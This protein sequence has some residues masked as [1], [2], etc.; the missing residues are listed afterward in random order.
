VLLA[1]AAAAGC[2]SSSAPRDVQGVDAGRPVDASALDGSD[3]SRDADACSVAC[4]GTCTAG[5]CLETLASGV[6]TPVAIAVDGT[7]VYATIQSTSV[8]AVSRGG[9]T[10]VTLAARPGST[11]SAWG[12][13]T[14]AANVYWTEQDVGVLSAPLVGGADGGTVAT[15][16]SSAS[17]WGLALQGDALYWSQIGVVFDLTSSEMKLDLAGG[18]PV[19]L[20]SNAGSP[21]DV[22]T[23]AAN[24]YWFD[25]G[26][27]AILRTPLAGGAVTTLA[28]QQH[29]TVL[30][31][32]GAN[33]YWA[34]SVGQASSVVML[35]LAGGAPTTVA[36]SAGAS[37]GMAT[38][39]TSVYWTSGGTQAGG[40][41]DG[42]VT[43][44]PSGGGQVVTLATGAAWGVA[45]DAESV[46]WADT[47]AERVV[48]LTPK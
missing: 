32:D 20:V 23:D 38:D 34:D 35:P 15:L 33:L 3:A 43:R 5:R 6:G 16:A 36:T 10:P 13:V 12:L 45:V 26:T 39:G 28:T 29:A 37:Y 46:Y 21:E 44:M 31:V 25:A 8:I 18:A 40:Y 7:N 24:L 42:V 4:S 27:L 17:A 14:D 9:G 11:F 48:K 22:V 47:G 2:S 41:A 1:S 19:T 30:A